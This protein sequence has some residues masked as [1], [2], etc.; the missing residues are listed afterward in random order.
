MIRHRHM[1][2]VA[3]AALALTV[4]LPTDPEPPAPAPKRG[5]GKRRKAQQDRPAREPTT[6]LDHERLRL[7]AIRRAGKAA[8]QSKGMKP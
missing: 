6:P 7:A 3:G 2:M 4:A 8:R 1:A 5:E